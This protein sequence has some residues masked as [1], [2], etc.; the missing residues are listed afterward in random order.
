MKVFLN[1]NNYE[2]GCPVVYRIDFPSGKFYIGSTLRLFVR[3]GQYG[4]QIK[5]GYPDNKKFREAL[6]GC[7]RITFS[8]L[9]SVPDPLMTRHREDYYLKLHVDNPKILNRAMSAFSNVGVRWASEEKK[10]VS[11]TLLGNPKRGRPVKIPNRKGYHYIK[12]ADRKNFSTV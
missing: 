8:V 12:V 4:T 6:I 5:A 10:K 3:I 1:L 11:K 9:E 7:D 2:V